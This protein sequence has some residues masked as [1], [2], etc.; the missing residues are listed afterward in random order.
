MSETPLETLK[1]YERLFQEGLNPGPQHW[2]EIASASYALGLWSQAAR[3]YMKLL[4]NQRHR[5]GNAGTSG[6]KCVKLAEVT[7]SDNK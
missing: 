4:T 6:Q 5:I 1:R 2:H 7:T 3:A